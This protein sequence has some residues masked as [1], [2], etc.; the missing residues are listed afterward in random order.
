MN[1]Q[2]RNKL[3][4][5]EF[6]F[7]SFSIKKTNIIYNKA[8][9][10]KLSLFINPNGVIDKNLNC[11]ELEMQVLISDSENN[12]EAE[13]IIVGIFSFKENINKEVLDS[14]FYLNAPAI[15]FPFIRT[16]I[17]TLTSLSGI[18]TITLPI[19]NLSSV[20]DLKEKTIERDIKK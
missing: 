10:D 16:Y 8:P 19:M 11:F 12:F 4:I 6:S 7:E 2:E 17:H 1:K 20:I 9:N 3:T 15:L 14:Y 13:I 5:S 18:G